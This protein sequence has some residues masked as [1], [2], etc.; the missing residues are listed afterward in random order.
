MASSVLFN[1]EER[2]LLLRQYKELAIHLNDSVPYHERRLLRM[3]LKGAALGGA[4]QRDLNGANPFVALLGVCLIMTKELSLKRRSTLS[5]ILFDAISSGYITLE[6][7]NSLFKTDI[8][9]LVKGLGKINEL[10]EKR[11][12]IQS[13]NFSKLLLTFSEDLRVV[14]IMIA[15][16]LYILRV[17]MRTCVNEELRMKYLSEASYLY[18]PLCHRLG[19]YKIK[20]EMEDLSLKYS[21][22]EIYSEI[23]QKL[24]E[25]KRSRD[26]FIESFIQPVEEKIQTLGIAFEIKGRTKSIHSIYNKLRK[27]K[28]EFEKI[29]DLFAI[30]VVV[31]VPIEQEK[32]V[33][34]NIYSIITDMYQPNPKRLK[35]WI[36]IPKSNGYESLHITV[37][38]PENR[39]VEVQI[40]SARM[41]EIAESGLAAH[42]KYKGGKA[43]RG[44][45]EW[46][47]SMREILEYAD[48]TPG[49]IMQELKPDSVSNEI[50]IF[51]PKGDV[52][53]LPK[54]ATVLDFA[55]E[56][57]TT[58][59]CKCVGAK[60][61]NKNVTIKH[62]LNSG[63]QVEILTSPQQTPK[64][65]WLNIVKTSRAKVKIK[66]SFKEEENKLATFGKETF[67]RRMKN[68]K[69]EIEEPTLMR[70]IK[71]EGYKMVNSF[72]ADLGAEK[73]D[74]NL[75]IEH[76][77]D[78]ERKEREGLGTE[79]KTADTYVSV[80][81]H[82]DLS[83]KD[84][85]I[86]IDRDLK[87][88]D[89]KL[90]KC[91]NPIYGDEVFGFLS[92]N[93]GIKIHRMQCP[94]AH[95]MF[96]RFGYRILK[97]R[98]T[99][100]AGSQYPITLYVIGNDDIGIVT[101]IT[102]II[103]KEKQIT[104][105]AISI[106][107]HAGL[108]EGQLTVM[109]SD[110]SSLDGLIKKIKT[111]KGVKNVSRTSSK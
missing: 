53:K 16:R 79:S 111:I 45:D 54:G 47:K 50:Y 103:N 28:I 60:I 44:M 14:L 83:A 26:A 38:G 33:C 73:I 58:L 59:G 51:T 15:D 65:D 46:L 96:T 74:V 107:T 57:H 81:V 30:R 76:Y 68:R 78:I 98:W 63:D 101:N 99:G 29:Y 94:N 24:K 77:I 108:F 19:L 39:W 90:A 4:Y 10:Y 9:I 43:E 93:G 55:F 109:V 48:S 36:S 72:F 66:Q 67:Y 75:M 64:R 20:S 2:L 91:C 49:D 110:T 37:L 105:R 3:I 5:F 95:E 27:Q 1:S 6:E 87:G 84:D 18:A 21:N 35:D 88:I 100:K 70:L 82:E 80:P 41:D 104:L 40:R 22:R 8:S 69:L 52:Y 85:E 92:I 34:W 71:K 17:V 97:A 12:A 62:E 61:G 25:T 86:V 11:P 89:Y 42:W 56:I 106:D 23:A 102:S 13:E 7:V 32:I 31:D